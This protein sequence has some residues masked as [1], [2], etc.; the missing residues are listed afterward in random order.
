MVKET[1]VWNRAAGDEARRALAGLGDDVELLVA[2]S[3]FR[4]AD[5]GV[6]SLQL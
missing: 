3:R 1:P 2:E 5:P 4:L 6:D